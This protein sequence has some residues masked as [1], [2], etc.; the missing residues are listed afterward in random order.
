MIQR[1]ERLRFALEAREAVGVMGER[2][3]ENLDGNVPVEPRI[4]RAKDSP[5]PPAPIAATISYDPRRA[6]GA[7]DMRS[8]FADCNGIRQVRRC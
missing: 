5:I 2:V 8:K 4:A 1:G 3:G 6:P 7:R